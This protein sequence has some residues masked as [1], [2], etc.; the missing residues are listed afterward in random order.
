MNRDSHL[1]QVLDAIDDGFC[2]LELIV[3]EGDKITDVRYCDANKAFEKHTRIA[4]IEGRLASDAIPDLEDHWFEHFQEVYRNGQSV[5]LFENAEKSLGCWFKVSLIRIGEKH[6]RRLACIFKDVTSQVSVKNT[7]RRFTS[8][9]V[10]GDTQKYNLLA[11]LAH[12]LRNPLAPMKHGIDML[13]DPS[14]DVASIH[15]IQSMLA[16]QIGQLTKLVDNLLDASNIGRDNIKIERQQV[17]LS[18]IVTSAIE[19]TQGQLDSRQHQFE[20]E[21][22]ENSVWIQVD[23]ARIIQ[24]LTNLLN[25]AARYTPQGGH[26]R[27]AVSIDGNACSLQVTDNG[28]GLDENQSV[29]IFELFTRADHPDS[30]QGGLG[31]GLTIA[32]RLV[33]LHAGELSVSSKG[34]GSGSTFTVYLPNCVVDSDHSRAPEPESDVSTPVPPSATGDILIVDDSSDSANILSKILCNKGYSAYAAY[35]GKSALELIHSRNPSIVFCDIGLPDMTGYQVAI[36]LQEL[37]NRSEMTLIALTGWGSKKDLE[38]SIVAGFDHHLIKP[39]S[40]DSVMDLLTH[41]A[42]KDDSPQELD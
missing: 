32:K 38:R 19:A 18:D 26:I 9:V 34:L 36:E 39:V 3:D 40:I 16:R 24:T 6:D 11:L 28:I 8:D 15:E 2:V 13:R 25:N 22:P 27:L 35:D 7:L 33:N 30:M 12:E 31:V 21:M 23:P 41:I 20:S 10:E 29:D 1:K 14:S 37:D 42:Q 4:N 17:L 5:Q